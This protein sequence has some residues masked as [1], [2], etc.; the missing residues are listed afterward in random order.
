M[1]LLSDRRLLK[2]ARGVETKYIFSFWLD[3]CPT[4]ILLQEVCNLYFTVISVVTRYEDTLCLLF[5]VLVGLL[6][7]VDIL[8]FVPLTYPSSLTHVPRKFIISPPGGHRSHACMQYANRA[9]NIQN[10]PV[11]N[12]DANSMVISELREKVQALA[13]ELLRIRSG[14]GGEGGGDVSAETLRELAVASTPARQSPRPLARASFSRSGPLDASAPVQRE[15]TMLRARVAEAEGEVVR[16]T[17]ETKLARKREGDKD[18]A[19]AEARAELDLAHEAL[20][21]G[22]GT[23]QLMLDIAEVAAREGGGD[24]GDAAAATAASLVEAEAQEE[25][26]GEENISPKA[27]LGGVLKGFFSGSAG[28]TTRSKSTGSSSGGALGDGGGSQRGPEGETSGQGPSSAAGAPRGAKPEAA[29]RERALAVVKDFHQRIQALE[30]KL[31]DSER[32]R[33]TL[34]RQLVQSSG[35]GPGGGAGAGGAPLM[36]GLSAKLAAAA[37]GDIGELGTDAVAEAK[38]R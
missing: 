26:T 17:E 11:V 19:L 35:G 8:L 18:D 20:R 6:L 3:S 4:C 5:F 22:T 7:G 2:L 29:A 23:D 30:G 28:S 9:R 25:S 24:S 27:R 21:G 38:K 16:L 32:Q 37:A 14:G 12:R 15:L 34:E 13:T 10:K 36:V 31:H 1:W 33:A